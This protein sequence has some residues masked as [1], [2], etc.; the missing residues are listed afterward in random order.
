MPPPELFNF[1]FLAAKVDDKRSENED[2]GQERYESD[3]Y[4]SP[5]RS[6]DGERNEKLDDFEV[7]SKS[8][9]GQTQLERDGF[10]SSSNQPDLPRTPMQLGLEHYR[11]RTVANRT[12]YIYDEESPHPTSPLLHV[13]RESRDLLQSLGYG[14]GFSTYTSPARLWFNFNDDVLLL[15][16]VPNFQK[17][18]ILDGGSYNMGQCPRHELESVRRLALPIPNSSVYGYDSPIP[19]DVHEAVQLFGNLKELLIIHR[20]WYEEDHMGYLREPSGNATVVDVGHEE[21]WGHYLG[22]T[23]PGVHERWHPIFK[24]YS[25]SYT[26]TLDDIA[27]DFESQLRSHHPVAGPLMDENRP[28]RELWMTPK[29]RFVVLLER[30]D[31]DAFMESRRN[32]RAHIDDIYWRQVALTSAPSTN[33]EFG[34]DSRDPGRDFRWYFQARKAFHPN[35]ED[36]ASPYTMEWPDASEVERY[37][38]L[39]N[40]SA[41]YD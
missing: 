30:E 18:G 29:V 28:A 14:L 5:A 9:Q 8:H 39:L 10:D 34:D 35:P 41:S 36:W 27:R 1:F 20:D 19:E 37:M 13:C 11:K 24:S 31:E 2:E 23:V 6:I 4:A 21:I 7:F 17:Y 32:F 25:L 33:H 26:R 16:K 38:N 15:D 40:G 22:W 12:A 3:E